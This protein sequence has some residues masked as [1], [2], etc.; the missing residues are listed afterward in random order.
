[1]LY[2]EH[3]STTGIACVVSAMFMKLS[4]LRQEVYVLLCAILFLCLVKVGDV[5]E[6]KF[7][8]VQMQEG[9]IQNSSLYKLY[10]LLF[11]VI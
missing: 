10:I 7:F 9:R 8:L 6:Q 3:T 5:A 4:Y 2:Y 11:A 1:M